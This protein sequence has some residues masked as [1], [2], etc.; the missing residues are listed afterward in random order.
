MVPG[1]GRVPDVYVGHLGCQA[2]L[3]CNRLGGLVAII[4]DQ[5]TQWFDSHRHK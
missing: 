4:P 5:S 1:P 3:V 2:N